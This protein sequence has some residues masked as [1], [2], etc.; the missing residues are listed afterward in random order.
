MATSGS[1]T[2]SLTRDSIIY[3]ALR[4]IGTAD[5]A[6]NQVTSN[7]T[8]AAEALNAMLKG[9]QVDGMPIWAIK[10]YTFTMVAGTNTYNIGIGQTLATPM[11]LKVIQAYRIEN[12]GAMNIPLNVYNHYDYNLL[13]QNATSGEPVNIFYQPL[14]TYGVIELWPTPAD[15]NTTITLV[16]QRPFEDMNSSSDNLDFPSYWTEA[17][18]FGLAWRL[19]YEYGTPIMDRQELQKAAEFFHTQALSFGTEEGSLFFQ[20][21]DTFRNK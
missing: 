16:Y 2:W 6:G 5:L 21:D 4:K 12:T 20:P 10:E 19:S 14:S 13:P 7:T 18:I 17:V 1:T 8:Y 15:S 9:F 3:A 11:P